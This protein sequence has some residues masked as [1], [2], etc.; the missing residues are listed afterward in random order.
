VYPATLPLLPLRFS[1]HVQVVRLLWAVG[2]GL[3]AGA[4]AVRLASG[5]DRFGGVRVPCGRLPV[6]AGAA[7]RR[8]S[9]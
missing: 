2:L 6:Q 1:A 4:A 9:P 7:D 3:L 8:A 5:R